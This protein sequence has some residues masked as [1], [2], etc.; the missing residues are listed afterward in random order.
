MYTFSA[1]WGNTFKEAI[2]LATSSW[3]HSCSTRM[4][5][6]DVVVV[7]VVVVLVKTHCAVSSPNQWPRPQSEQQQAAF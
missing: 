1:A 2:K 6:V 7:G 4:V 5:V 3:V